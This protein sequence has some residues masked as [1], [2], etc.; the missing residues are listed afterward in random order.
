MEKKKE[1]TKFERCAM[2]RI[3][4]IIAEYCDGSQQRFVERTKLNKAS[5]SQYVNGK[6]VPSNI[7]ASRIAKAFNVDP[8]WIMGFDVPKEPVNL[9]PAPELPD[10][11]PHEVNVINSY[12]TADAGIQKSVD[13]LLGV[14]DELEGKEGQSA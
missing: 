2:E 10:L 1:M 7:T 11:T 6:N 8:A 4:Q 13:I 9:S 5:V 12:R 3:N 14:N